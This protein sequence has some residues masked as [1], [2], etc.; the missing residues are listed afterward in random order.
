MPGRMTRVPRLARSSWNLSVLEIANLALT[1]S[2]A[3]FRD[4]AQPGFYR[5]PEAKASAWRF[6][7]LRSFASKN[8]RTVENDRELLGDSK[9]GAHRLRCGGR[10]QARR[11]ARACAERLRACTAIVRGTNDT[12]GT[13]LVDVYNL[14]LIVLDAATKSP[15]VLGKNLFG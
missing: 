15:K 3:A 1:S 4:V 2:C 12:T 6:A 8:S 5:R 7:V 11:G 13:G 14:K 10:P 9:A